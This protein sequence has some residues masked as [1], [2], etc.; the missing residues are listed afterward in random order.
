[1]P[2]IQQIMP[3]R[4]ELPPIAQFELLIGVSSEFAVQLFQLYQHSI[5]TAA[6]KPPEADS[7]C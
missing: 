2:T 1:M 3:V 5:A 7:T 6:P 4:A